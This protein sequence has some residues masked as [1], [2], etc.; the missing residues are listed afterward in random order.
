VQSVV[1]GED[2]EVLHEFALRCHGLRTDTGTTGSEVLGAHFGD[3]TLKITVE[4]HAAE[5][6]REFGEGH[7]WIAFEEVP[8]A[9]ESERISRRHLRRQTHRL[10]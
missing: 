10:N 2:V 3:E 7:G 5:G 9:G 1:A 8:K 4:A 6:L